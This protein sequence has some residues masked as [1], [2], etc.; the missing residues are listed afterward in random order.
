V[1]IVAVTAVGLSLMMYP[2]A[3]TWFYLHAQSQTVSGY[4][5]QV[6][7]MPAPQRTDLLTAAE[8]YNETLPPGPF[9]DPESMADNPAGTATD[10]EYDSLL[11]A[12]GSGIMAQIAIPS[13]NVN[14]PVYHGV[15]TDT[16]EQGVGH[17]PGSSLPVGGA[18]THAVL[19]AHTGV[20]NA[21]LFTDLNKVVLG[22]TFTITTYGETLYYRVDQILVVKPD[23][24]DPL[25]IFPGMD[26]VTLVTCTPK[27]V[28]T[29]RLLVRGVRIAAPPA[30]DT[31]GTY[32]L[33]V[34]KG[35][36]LPWWAV[37]IAGGTVASLVITRLLAVGSARSS[38]HRRRRSR[39]VAYYW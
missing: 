22:D 16:L 34:D 38:R 31:A 7:A 3:G 19:V 18:G 2:S 33:G 36:G 9:Q 14:L 21:P 6:A 12:D 37:V 29:Y 23:D 30:A 5:Q 20:A 26:Y 39:R 1:A 11:D 25:Q 17:L 10:A 8:A 35:P 4:A 24:M 15:S 13:I 32:A 28:N 27:W